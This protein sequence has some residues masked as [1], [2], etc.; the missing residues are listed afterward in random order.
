MTAGEVL[1]SIEAEPQAISPVLDA[2]IAGMAEFLA[3]HLDAGAPA[4][5]SGPSRFLKEPV[6]FGGRHARPYMLT[7][8]TW[9]MR[10]R[11]LF[12]G[13][14]SVQNVLDGEIAAARRVIECELRAA[15]QG[16]RLAP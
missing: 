6:F 4:W 2:H 3:F 16:E 15:D 7:S 9:S 1:A 8:T 12:C 13:E 10:R 14:V 5:A 11:N